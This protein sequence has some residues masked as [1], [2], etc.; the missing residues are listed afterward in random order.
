MEGLTDQEICKSLKKLYDESEARV[1]AEAMVRRAY[2]DKISSETIS[3]KVT[4]Q[5]NA[6]K[7]GIYDINPR[8]KEGSKNYYT[9]KQL[10]SQ[11]LAYY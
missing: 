8:F 2:T 10:V 3:E 6:I 7:I 9:T 11:T 1:K 4:A 5:M